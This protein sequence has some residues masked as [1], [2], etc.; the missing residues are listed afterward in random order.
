MSLL[1]L[2]PA[3]LYCA[4]GDFFIDPWQPVARA[5]VT[6]AHGDHLRPGSAA[7]LV[8]AP[9]EALAR[10]R[11][12]FDASLRSVPYGEA[13]L[14]NGVRVSLHPAGHLL[15]SAQVRI[16]HRGEVW[17]V[18]GDY[19]LEPDPTCAPFEPL[20][21]HGF[22]TECTFGLPVYRWT[23]Q[24]EVFDELNAW[25][26]GNQERG[27][28]TMLLGYALGKA[29]RLLAGLDPAIGPICT[30]GAMDRMTTLYREAGVALA[31]TAPV[32]SFPARHDWSRSLIL[33]P[34]GSQV[35]PW[36][37]RFGDA[38]TGFA[39]GW[40]QVRGNRRR[41]ALDRGFALS[42][43]VDWPSLLHAVEATGATTVW[44]THGFTAP[45]VR[46][47]IERGLDARALTTRFEGELDTP[48]EPVE[49]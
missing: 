45:L 41:Q 3:G 16:E 43:H 36:A 35:T 20:R 6:H 31:P 30:H 11:L 28:A 8:A 44:A 23:P 47:L 7:Y 9:G 38:A 17:V 19:K 2:T 22:V 25:W 18:S 29:Q 49:A 34:P 5:I 24:Q 4:A 39:S 42:D 15:G 37:R 46:Y 14:L 13:H 12:P 33:A 21:C 32:S 40:M 1:E 26:R 27:R 48:E 10:A